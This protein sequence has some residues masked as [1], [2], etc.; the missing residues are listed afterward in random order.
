LVAVSALASSCLAADPEKVLPD[1]TLFFFK[2]KNVSE[3]RESFQGSSF[4]QLLADPAMKPMK[5]D[6]LGKM[7]DA[8]KEVKAKLGVTIGELFSLPQGAI[9]LA[10]VGKSDPKIP[11]AVLISAD[12]GKNASTMTEVMTKSTD[13]AKQANAKV[14][15]ETFKGLTLHIIQSPQEGDKPNPPMVWTN[16]GSVF[17]IAT[18]VDAIKDVISHADGRS[19]SLAS[20][21]SFAKTRAKLGDAPVSWFLDI[22]KTI[23]LM[24]KLGQ[25]A[26]PGGQN[27]EPILQITGINGLKAASGSFAFNS[28][29]YD[30]VSKVYFLAPAPTQG[31]LKMFLMPPA[32]LKPE[33]WVPANVASYSSFSW[34]LDGAYNAL[35]DLVNQVQPGMLQAL[36]QQALVG[37]NGGDPLDLQ[38]DVFGPLGNRITMISDFKK[39]IKEDSQRILVGISLT[40]IKKFQATF[41]KII[42]IAGGSPAKRDFLGTTIYDF[43]IPDMPNPAGGADGPLKSGTA[44]IALAK[45]TLFIASEPALLEAVLRGGASP[46]ADSPDFLAFAKQ[47]PGKTSTLNY[48]KPD[49]SARAIYDSIKSGEFEKDMDKQLKNAQGAPDFGKMF[50]KSK[51]PDFSVFAKYMSG[52]GGFGLMEDDGVTFTNFSLR[53]GNP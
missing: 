42:E 52:S 30:S 47:T 17:H 10:V 51:L 15:T 13:Q 36:Q 50:D 27:I 12:A 35:N 4:G 33:S 26:Q 23:K 34:D 3:L 43:K 7:A 25:A 9:T 2:V 45:D 39:P 40:D 20:V 28:G 41:N 18:D 19:D 44:T 6:A 16:S 11:F 48:G 46:L 38:K 22:T 29:A 1:S 31:V 8:S 32:N 24:V 5:E 49:E 14:A 53:K 37:P 21:D